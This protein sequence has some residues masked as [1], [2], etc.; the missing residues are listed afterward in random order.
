MFIRARSLIFLVSAYVLVA[1]N[2]AAQQ[3]RIGAR[4]SNG[5]TVVLA[6]HVPT[7]AR[8]ALDQGPVAASFP[9]PLITMYLTPSSSQQA[10]LRQLLADQQ[11]SS[12]ANF[13]K[14]LSP[15]QYAD[16]F[17]SSQNDINRITAWLQSQ[18]LQL[19]HVARSRSFIQFSGSASQVQA[20]L[21]VQIDQYLENGKVHYANVGDPA[22]PAALSGIVRGF[23]GL[24]NF[25]PKPRLIAGP[26]NPS[27]TSGEGDHQIVPDD[28]A[29]IYDVARLY[30]AGIDGT[31]QKLAVIGQTDINLSDITTFRS[32]YGLPANPPQKVLV[33]RSADPGFSQDDIPEADLDV[34]WSGA[35]ARKASIIFVYSDDVNI[36]LT[37]AIDQASAPV[38]SM[39][40]G[41]CEEADL[42]QPPTVSSVGAASQFGRHHLAERVGGLRRG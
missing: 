38:I 19:E 9:L 24:H 12:S 34:E 1:L 26:A 41:L 25:R 31:G 15:E 35:V 40:Y 14:W 30:A 17:G 5:P 29:T 13:H 27:N 42:T 16:Q 18:G 33:P 28:F 36:S 23:H 8:A 32:K 6:G 11:N 2:A 37:Y 7:R 3:D 21:H 10:S 22:I 20:A 4:I 39:S